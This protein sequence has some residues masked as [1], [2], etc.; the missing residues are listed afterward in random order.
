MVTLYARVV[1]VIMPTQHVGGGGVGNEEIDWYNDIGCE[2][3]IAFHVI[4]DGYLDTLQ[5]FVQPLLHL[6]QTAEQHSKLA[7]II[8]HVG[9]GVLF[10]IFGRGLE[11]LMNEPKHA[12]VKR[13]DV[14]VAGSSPK[15]LLPLVM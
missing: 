14:I 11:H 2:C 1:I 4:I 6:A 10:G 5:A 9:I 15:R 7:V 3:D 13:L 8:L 12:A